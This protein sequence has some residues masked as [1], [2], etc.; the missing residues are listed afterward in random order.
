MSMTEQPTELPKPKP[1]RKPRRRARRAA[2]AKAPAPPKAASMFAGLAPGKCADAC[3]VDKCVIS[4]VGICASP[5]QG[6]LQASLQNP[7]TLARF[8]AAKR[9]LGEQKLDLTNRG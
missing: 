6:G 5:G 2:P 9:Y 1:H 4:G 3:T 8:N 7:E